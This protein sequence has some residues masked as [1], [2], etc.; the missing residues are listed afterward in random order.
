MA[1]IGSWDLG[2]IFRTI[3]ARL[4]AHETNPRQPSLV[5]ATNPHRPK[6]P[7]SCGHHGLG[8]AIRND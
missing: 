1:A 7:F 5:N 8:A 2:Q 4:W 6:P 3:R